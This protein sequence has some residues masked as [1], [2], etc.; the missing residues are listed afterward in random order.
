MPNTHAQ[1]T[2]VTA[3]YMKWQKRLR[4]FEENTHGVT[5]ADVTS[6][7]RAMQAAIREWEKPG[8]DETPKQAKADRKPKRKSWWPKFR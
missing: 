4:E 6:A 7:Y 5:Q 8:P 3:A 2:I 1:V